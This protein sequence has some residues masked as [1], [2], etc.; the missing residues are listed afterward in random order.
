MQ[1][2]PDCFRFLFEKYGRD[3]LLNEKKFYALLTDYLPTKEKE[4][5]ILKIACNA[6]VYKGFV[7]LEENQYDIQRKK[8]IKILTDDYLLGLE[9]AE[10]AIDWLMETLGIKQSPTITQKAKPKQKQV[11]IQANKYSDDYILEIV[12]DTLVKCICKKPSIINIPEGVAVIGESAFYNCGRLLGI[13]LP[14]GLKSIKANAFLKRKSL[15]SIKIPVSC[16][17]IDGRAFMDCDN[18]KNVLY[19]GTVHEWSQIRFGFG[20][21]VYPYTLFIAD[22]IAENICLE[23]VVRIN[24]YAFWFCHSLQKVIIKNRVSFIGEYA[25]AH[26][27]E[28]TELMIDG[29]Q[30]VIGKNAF[31]YCDKLKKLEI[32][33]GVVSIESAFYWCKSL[34]QVKLGENLKKIGTNAFRLCQFKSLDIPNSVTE[35]GD[36]AFADCERLERIVIKKSVK[37]IGEKAFDRCSDLKIYC[38]A[39]SKPQEWNDNWN[40]SNRPVVWGYKENLE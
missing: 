7:D 31:S 3:I 37:K 15:T 25:F 23:D 22:K 32:G 38:E 12:G 33:N 5:K 14:N 18:L 1:N 2:I 34:Y 8:A 19:E 20:A 27:K 4:L 9:W 24:N 13:E 30:L 6:G 10:M 35:I 40:S 39:A 28:L 16:I 29:N 11:K 36:W 21:M 26:C 17:E